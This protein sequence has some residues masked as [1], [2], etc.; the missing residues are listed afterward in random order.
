[1]R[2]E[3]MYFRASEEEK[4]KIRRNAEKAGLDMTKYIRSA[5]LKRKIYA[6]PA[7]QL[8]KAYKKLK[9]ILYWLERGEEHD[10]KEALEE[11]LNLLYEAYLF[12][13]ERKEKTNTT[14]STAGNK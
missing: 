3:K 4:E 2:R 6:A 8:E 14:N 11:V 13:K 9:L 5:A 12:P 10:L 1:M 7:P